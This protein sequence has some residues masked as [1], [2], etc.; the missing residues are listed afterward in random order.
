VKGLNLRAFG[1]ANYRLFFYGQ[2]VSVIGRGGII[3][4]G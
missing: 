3:P 2:L 4:G 1:N